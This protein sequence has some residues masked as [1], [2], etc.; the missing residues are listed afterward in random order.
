MLDDYAKSHKNSG[1]SHKA[2]LLG[3]YS[4]NTVRE[5]TAVVRQVFPSAICLVIDLENAT[6]AQETAEIS[7]FAKADARKLPFQGINTI[8]T[9][10]LLDFISGPMVPS[11]KRDRVLLFRSC[12]ETLTDGG[13]LMMVEAL[14]NLSVEKLGHEL[15][16]V[17]FEDIVIE[18]AEVFK[19]RRDMDRYFRG[20]S[21]IA[22]Q[23]ESFL[24]LSSAI[25]A[26]K[27]PSRPEIAL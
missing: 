17:G 18:R 6:L 27:A 2:L 3:A 15:R 14:G 25:K 19:Y 20:T 4:A 9:N 26:L 8:Y 21:S 5:Y 22:P 16:S 10:H 11:R 23:G 12:F 13:A 1:E 7:L 24:G